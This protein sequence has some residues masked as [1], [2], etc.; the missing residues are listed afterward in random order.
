MA[1]QSRTEVEDLIRDA[2]AAAVA[3]VEQRFGFLLGEQVSR[4]QAE[5]ALSLVVSE[6]RAESAETSARIDRLCTGYNAEFV[7]H[8]EAIL[9]TVADFNVTSAEFTSSVTDARQET[10]TLSEQN[11]ELSGSW[12]KL[13][14]DIGTAFDEQTAKISSVMEDVE[15]GQGPQG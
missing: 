15:L 9:A 3:G 14:G 11:V 10:K 1:A 6:A 5:G 13:H 8:K 4:A 2:V 12:A 7:Q